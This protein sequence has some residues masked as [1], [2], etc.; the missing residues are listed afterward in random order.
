MAVSCTAF[1]LAFGVELQKLLSHVAQRPSH[2][3]FSARPGDAAQPI[4]DGLG[5]L[6][7]AIFLNQVQ[8]F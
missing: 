4:K 2:P 3:R 7:A 8:P 6:G 1:H 5:T